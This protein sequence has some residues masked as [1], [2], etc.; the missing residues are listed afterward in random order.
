MCDVEH[1]LWSPAGVTL[2][3]TAHRRHTRVLALDPGAIGLR[4]SLAHT[5]GSQ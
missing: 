5:P 1:L 2:G 4:L 3:H